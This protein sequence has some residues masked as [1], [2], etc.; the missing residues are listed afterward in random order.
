MT[1]KEKNEMVETLAGQ[2]ASTNRFYIIDAEGLNVE[3][4]NDFRRKCFQ[5]GVVYQV[6]KNTKAK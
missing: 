6:V 2:L 5:A 3:E 1:R 4:I